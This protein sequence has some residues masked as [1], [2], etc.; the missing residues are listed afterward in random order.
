VSDLDAVS[1]NVREPAANNGD[2]LHVLVATDDSPSGERISHR[3]LALLQ[4]PHRVTLLRVITHVPEDDLT[5]YEDDDELEDFA[6]ATPE[7]LAWRWDI[8]LGS[9]KGEL[10]R[11]AEVFAPVQVDER[12]EAGDVAGTICDVARKLGVDTIV[13]GAH[14]RSRLRRL[15]IRSVSQH[16]VRNA[17][18]PVLVVPVEVS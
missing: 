9:A 13:I 16:V 6:D 15:F 7:Q 5:P 3:A 8:E 1:S 12:L 14:A 10:H 11:T 18:C 4:T 17:P 2:G